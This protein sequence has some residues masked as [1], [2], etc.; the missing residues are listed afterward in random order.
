MHPDQ[1]VLTEQVA[2]R[3][4][5]DLLPGTD[6]ATVRLLETSATTS[7]V[8]RIGEDLAARFPLEPADPDSARAGLASEHEARAEFAP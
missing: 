4:I 2:T 8:V 1:L 3:L 7:T 5:T 6:P